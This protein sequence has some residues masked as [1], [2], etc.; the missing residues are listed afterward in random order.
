MNPDLDPRNPAV[1]NL[2][3][4]LYAEPL[5]NHQP[6]LPVGCDETWDRPQP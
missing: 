1:L 2:L 3:T 4:E 6:P 5:P